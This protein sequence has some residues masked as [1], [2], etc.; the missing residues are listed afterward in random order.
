MAAAYCVR[1]AAT[2]LA[3]LWLL[4][5]GSLAASQI[6]VGV[7]RQSLGG[8]LRRGLCAPRSCPDSRPGKPLAPA[9]LHLGCLWPWARAASRHEAVK[10]PELRRKRTDAL[11]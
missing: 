10:G 5:F 1:Q 8:R 9:G 7:R 11:L 6:E 4:C 2:V 3:A